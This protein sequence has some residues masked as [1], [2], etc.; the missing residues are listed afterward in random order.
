[1]FNLRYNL[2]FLKFDDHD[3]LNPSILWFFNLQI[4]YKLDYQF[5]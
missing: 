4:V 5:Y 1:M 3:Q 2:I